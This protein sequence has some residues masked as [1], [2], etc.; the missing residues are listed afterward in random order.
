MSAIPRFSYIVITTDDKGHA[1]PDRPLFLATF[2][3]KY[4]AVQYARQLAREL[5][6]LDTGLYRVQVRRYFNNSTNS[7]STTVYDSWKP[8]QYDLGGEG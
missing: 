2:T 5:R 8:Q 7:V 1:M 6:Q 3:T 4:P